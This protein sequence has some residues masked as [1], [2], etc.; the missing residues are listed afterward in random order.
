MYIYIYI[1]I[2]M[3]A[4]RPSRGW[5]A[6][7][8]AGR[9]CT[10]A[11]TVCACA[12]LWGCGSICFLLQPQLVKVRECVESECALS[13]SHLVLVWGTIQEEW[14]SKCHLR[15][16]AW[17]WKWIVVSLTSCCF[18]SHCLQLSWILAVR[19][20]RLCDCLVA[21]SFSVPRAVAWHFA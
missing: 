1:Y 7:L 16:S 21:T 19:R 4:V 5:P 2:Y 13:P 10:Q 9:F 15:M 12:P 3:A 6:L 17:G 14:P 11:C 8:P 18:P 20:V